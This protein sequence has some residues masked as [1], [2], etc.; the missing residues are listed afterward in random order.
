MRFRFLPAAMLLLA[1]APAARAQPDSLS[2]D[3]LLDSV[4]Q[5]AQDNLDTNALRAFQDVDQAKLR[6]F[7]RDF[8]QRF[9]GQYVVNVAALKQT[10][11]ALLPLLAAHPETRS[12]AA[13]LRARLDYLDVAEQFQLT[14]PPPKAEPGR[15]PPP[16]PNPSAQLE[17]KT[18]QNQLAREPAPR[19]A[20]ALVPRLKPI[21]TAARVPPQLVWLAEVES[22]FDPEARSPVGAAGLYQLMPATARRFGLSLRPADQRLQPD[23][24][25]RA[26]ARYLRT[27]H[28]HFHDWR[29]SL[30]AYNAGEGAVQKL[31]DRYRTRS[32]DRIATHLPAETQMYV[33]RVEATLLRR[34]GVPLAKLAEPRG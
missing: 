31:L 30:A 24:S 19:G 17:R 14:I 20:D 4:Q 6:Q 26:A 22:S 5:W 1:F 11:N 8:Q 15:P 23:D 18:W 12:Y 29:L 2:L 9:Q 25:A 21:F 16:A 27:L 33:P 28:D 13:W 3:D 34:E 7:L 10:A 32:F